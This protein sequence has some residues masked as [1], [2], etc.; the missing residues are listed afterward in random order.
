MHKTNLTR[1]SNIHKFDTKDW[2]IQDRMVSHE[3]LLSYAGIWT[4]KENM[5]VE[6]WKDSDQ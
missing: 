4:F 3:K 6:I 2:T 1:D 5:L